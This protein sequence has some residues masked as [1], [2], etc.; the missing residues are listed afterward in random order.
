LIIDNHEITNLYHYIII[1]L[2]FFLVLLCNDINLLFKQDI[3]NG[4]VL[5]WK[6]DMVM[7]GSDVVAENEREGT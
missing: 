1:T 2:D 3:N 4:L 7:R 5:I 6:R